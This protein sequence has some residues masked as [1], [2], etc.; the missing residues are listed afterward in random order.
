MII[1]LK[2]NNSGKVWEYVNWVAKVRSS[3]AY[4]YVLTLICAK[5]GRLTC[6]DGKRLHTTHHNPLISAKIKD[7]MYRVLKSGQT[8]WIDRTDDVSTDIYPHT[9]KVIPNYFDCECVSVV[10]REKP[11]IGPI[12]LAAQKISGRIY[13]TDFLLDAFGSQM[14]DGLRT[15]RHLLFGVKNDDRN[16]AITIVNRLGLSVIM[17]MTP[18]DGSSEVL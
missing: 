18:Y 11:I 16:G 13:S 2:K 8:I 9:D 3:D 6:T 12:I 5:D 7:G 10:I 1:E 4:R 17:P 14:G 15:E